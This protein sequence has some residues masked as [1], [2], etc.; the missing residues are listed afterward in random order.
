MS[1]W[2]GTARVDVDVPVGTEMSGFAARSGP[3]DGVHDPL[4][5]RALVLDDVALVAVDVCGLHERTIAMVR[6]L[7][8]DEVREAV[9]TATHTHSGPCVAFER[10]GPHDGAVHDAVVAAVVAA[11]RG[12]VASRTACTVRYGETPALGIANNRR[13]DDRLTDPPAQFLRFESEGR[14]AAWL[15]V[16]PA[17]PVMLDATNRSISGDFPSYV[18]D[19]L[20]AAT[21]GALCVYATGAAGDQNCGQQV[22][23][24]YDVDS[25]DERT[26]AAAERIGTA[27]AEAVLAAPAREVGAASAAVAVEPVELPIERVD[28]AQARAQAAKWRAEIAAGVSP[29]REALLGAWLHWSAELLAGSYDHVPDAWAGTVTAVTLGDVALVALPGEPFLAT[30]TRIA[31]QAPTHPVLVLGYAN[32]CPGYV[33][34]ADEYPHGGYEVDDAHRYYGMPGPFATGCAERLETAALRALS[35]LPEAA[36][37]THQENQAH[38]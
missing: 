28:V 2:V 11:V 35:T 1:L 32:G 29:Q 3:S 7:L 37:S 23:L 34:P 16:L 8:G 13:H 17:H 24:T 30:A 22:D 19:R 5:V 27:L 9:V 38:P 6:E 15:V 4:T 25:S 10:L 18:R 31:S 12:A 33:P 36:S 14:T 21:P 20:E 26:F